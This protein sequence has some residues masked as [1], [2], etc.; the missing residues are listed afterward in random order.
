[1]ANIIFEGQVPTEMYSDLGAIGPNGENVWGK[2]VAAT[3]MTVIGGINLIADGG[4]VA[5]GAIA[6]AA[7]VAGAVGTVSG[8]LRLMTTELDTL[9]TDL[10]APADAVVAA[11]AAGSAS[12]KLRRLTTD[13]SAILTELLLKAKLTDTQPTSVADGQNVALGAIAD[14][15]VV[16][17]AAG[18]LSAKQRSISR[19]VGAT[20]AV[21][22]TTA[23]AAVVAGA[24]GSLSAKLRSLS[25]D[26]GAI[27]DAE[28]LKGATGSVS[29]K[30]RRI[31]DDLDAVL[32]AI[33]AQALLSDEQ[34]IKQMGSLKTLLAS[35]AIIASG[36]VNNTAVTFLDPYKRA[37]V[38]LAISLK[39]WHA[40][41]TLD[42]Y[43]QRSLDGGVSWDDICAFSQITSAAMPNGTYVADLILSGSSVADR[44]Q[45]DGA[46]AAHS[47]AT[48]GSWG[49]RLRV[50]TIAAN[51]NG[52]TDTITVAVNAYMVQ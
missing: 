31:S 41:A 29:A 9:M 52:T 22:G 39:T 18:S 36:T 17:G 34:P 28:V 45:V 16:A 48:V 32:T 42:V 4:D 12:A 6:D 11:G 40:G 10:G 14:A 23:D 8:K 20:A 37:A 5:E 25:R 49:D 35:V 26:I 15:A 21:E 47:V 1:M 33:K 51:L 38:T 46:L 2:V 27:D 50:K 43:I 24:T 7:P 3:T 44:V 30:L 19:D 13:L